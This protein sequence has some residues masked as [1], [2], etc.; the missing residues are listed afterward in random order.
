[1]VTGSR[2]CG[3]LSTRAAHSMHMQMCSQPVEQLGGASMHATH[4]EA[5]AAGAGDELELA[6]PAPK[7]DKAD[8]AMAA[9]SAELSCRSSR[10]TP[11]PLGSSGTPSAECMRPCP[12]RWCR[13]FNSPT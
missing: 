11:E 3:H 1:M 9:T 2:H 10:H 4:C 5:E 6:L 13:L 7:G 12:C 8:S